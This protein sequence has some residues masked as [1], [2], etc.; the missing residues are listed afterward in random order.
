MT[1]DHKL[2]VG[3]I[4]EVRSKQEIL[5]TLDKTGQLDGLPFMPQMFQY[6]G[7]RLRVSK[8]A[9]K[10]CDTINDFTGRRMEGAVHLEDVRCDGQAYGGCEA[11]CL[12]FWKL[13]W[14]K[15]SVDPESTFAPTQC[16][17]ADVVAGTQKPNGGDDPAYVC[18]A[19]QVLAATTPLPWWKLGQY[20]EDYTSGNVGLGK[21]LQGVIYQGYD[22]LINLGIG[23]GEPLRWFYD[24]FQRLRGGIPYPRRGGRIPLGQPTPST[25]LNLQPGE[26]V[27]V[28][29][30]ETILDTIDESNRNRGLYFDAELVP[31]CGGT[32][33]VLKRVTRIV[34]EKTGKMR[35]LKNPNI[36]LDDVF[37][38]SCYSDRRMFCPRSIYIYWREVWLEKASEPRPN[39][40]VND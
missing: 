7:R 18:Q 37:C 21:L 23:I 30:Y 31:Y 28:K 17:E 27:R 22:S 16:T 24:V 4:V 29:S 1:P 10:T 8:R 3:D 40:A 15:V 33:R 34:D 32:Y 6:C 5:R 11:G 13:A 20:V 19:T 14:L 38:R 36:I 2:R 35:E 25:K 9:H 12:I 26:V 39:K